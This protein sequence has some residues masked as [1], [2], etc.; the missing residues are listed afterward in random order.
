MNL[1]L[2]LNGL[3]KMPIIHRVKIHPQ[4]FED[5]RS[6]I[7]TAEY[8]F[9]D[10]NYHVND[11]VVLEEYIPKEQQITVPNNGYT[12]IVWGY[13]GRQL[14]RT[15]THIQTGYGIPEGYCVL[16]LSRI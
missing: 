12:E 4:P 11:I 3:D 13:T 15:I 7:K 10:R 6:G 14:T 2:N 8:R 9:N 16:S 1:Y 5:V